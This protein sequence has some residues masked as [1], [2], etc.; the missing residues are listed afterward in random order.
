MQNNSSKDN[1]SGFVSPGVENRGREMFKA[2]RNPSK[3]NDSIERWA[4][5]GFVS[6]GVMEDVDVLA[7]EGDR[8]I[9][10]RGRRLTARRS[11][12]DE[13]R[14]TEEPANS[15]GIVLRYLSSMYHG[16]SP[17]GY[18][19]AVNEDAYDENSGP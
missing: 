5:S 7:W 3:D 16:G 1:D 6:P 4:E 14:W 10:I 2:L 11:L 15:G 12:V 17:K 9:T 8:G 13:A 18:P 19:V